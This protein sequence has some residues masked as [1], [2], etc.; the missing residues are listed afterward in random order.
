MN[1]ERWDIITG[2]S[3][4]IATAIHNGHELRSE[5]KSLC[6]LDDSTRL[7]EEDPYTDFWTS[8]AP[9]RIIPKNSRFEVDLNRDRRDAVYIHPEDAWGLHIWKQPL[10]QEMVQ[11]SLDYYDAF[12]AN[13]QQIADKIKDKHGKFI[14][15][16]LH[17]YNHRRGGPDAPPADPTKNPEVNVGT[18]TMDR[19]RWA[20]L[21]DRCI[22]DLAAFDYVGRHLDVRENVKFYG[23]QLAH[24]IHTNYP[25]HGCCLAIE[26]KKFWM[27]EWSGQVDQ[28]QHRAILNA[29]RVTVTGLMEELQ[30]L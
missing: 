18:G 13:V 8:V 28:E 5:L 1:D 19:L 7:R 3:P 17:S 6:A 2:D 29:L 26:F 30:R 11:R 14:V 25:E 4:V 10:T 24:W 27:D 21:V 23:R 16:D 12:Y 9:T 20:P 22:Q 15:L